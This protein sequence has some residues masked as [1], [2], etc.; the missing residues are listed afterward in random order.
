MSDVAPPRRMS[1]TD[2]R[3]ALLDAAAALLRRRHPVALTFDAIAEAAGVSST[4]PYKYFASVDE[5]AEELYHRLVGPIDDETDDILA[6]PERP[7]ANKLRDGITLWCDVIR[8]DGVVLLRLADDVAHPS[9]RTSIERRRERAVEVW[10]AEVATEFDVD[11]VTARL[12][13]ASIT[14]S[15]I[16][17]LRRW[18]RDRLDRERVIDT[19]VTMALGQIEAVT[20]A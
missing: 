17:L 15:S 3:E 14:A 7:F 2:R 6:D 11:H 1:R 4:L 8:R 13:A 10:A 19:F 20:E 9:L 5:V 16:A 12:L 18:L